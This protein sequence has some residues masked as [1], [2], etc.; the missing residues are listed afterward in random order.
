MTEILHFL[1]TNQDILEELDKLAKKSEEEEKD[2]KKNDPPTSEKADDS[3]DY[4]EDLSFE[5]TN[6]RE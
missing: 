3:V 4:G 1:A 6:V 5:G 2:D